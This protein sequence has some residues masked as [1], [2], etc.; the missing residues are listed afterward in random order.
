MADP[1]TSRDGGPSELAMMEKLSWDE[2]LARLEA[3]VARRQASEGETP[4]DDEA[5]EEVHRRI[6]RYTQILL[7]S[8][9]GLDPSGVEDIAQ[10]VLLKLQTPDGLRRVQAAGNP[11]GYLAVIIRNAAND[12]ARS[13]RIERE[14]VAQLGL[15]VIQAIGPSFTGVADRTEALA[16]EIQQ[17]SHDERELLRLRFWKD[18]SLAEIAAEFGVSYS[19]IAVRMFRLLR[20]LRERLGLE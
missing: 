16:K 13:L 17:L 4:S 15:E 8:R 6:R 10:G 5:W 1:R 11:A 18:M 9:R 14:A 2:L 7:R 12:V 19:A 3:D 20:H